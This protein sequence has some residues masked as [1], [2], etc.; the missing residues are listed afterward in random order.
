MQRR[1][2]IYCTILVVFIAQLF[3]D[4]KLPDFSDEIS[5]AFEYSAQEL[6]SPGYI[7]FLKDK[8]NTKAYN[9]TYLYNHFTGISSFMFSEDR[10]KNISHNR[11]Q[12]K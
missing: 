7:L 9:L 11:F 4:D 5:V 3:E 6:T 1:L 12:R 10:K 8:K 2:L